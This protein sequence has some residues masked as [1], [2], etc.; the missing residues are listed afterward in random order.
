MLDL[1]RSSLDVARLQPTPTT[2]KKLFALSGNLCAFP[3]CTQKLVDDD[4]NL[5]AEICH[6][7][8]AKPGGERFNINQTDEERRDFANLILLCP[9]HHKVT[10][11]VA[12]YSV[13]VLGEMKRKHESQS[14]EKT[15]TPSDDLVKRILQEVINEAKPNVK[16]VS[17]KGNVS[18]LNQNSKVSQQIGYQQITANT[19]TIVQSKDKQSASSRGQSTNTSKGNAKPAKP[20]TNR[21]AVKLEL[22]DSLLGQLESEFVLAKHILWLQ[23]GLICLIVLSLLFYTIDEFS[24]LVLLVVIAPLILFSIRYLQISSALR[25]IV[26]RSGFENLLLKDQLTIRTTIRENA[27]IGIWYWD[28]YTR[29]LLDHALR[30]EKK[31]RWRRSR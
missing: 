12:K 18:I 20:Q 10:D 29:H 7:E 28:R 2:I 13:D 6:I 4:E 1:Q 9:N 3:G 22:R 16:N 19:V 17:K 21:E 30:V 14:H 5:T 15:I 23:I 26:N 8:A 31:P 24:P 25:G 27:R 11:D